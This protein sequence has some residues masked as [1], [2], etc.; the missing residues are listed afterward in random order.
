M[1][2]GRILESNLYTL[3]SEKDI[4]F[5]ASVSDESTVMRA[6]HIFMN[7][8]AEHLIVVI[9]GAAGA[10]TLIILISWVSVRTKRRRR[11]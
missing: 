1:V 9:A 2:D 11:Q 3:K 5:M 10:L 4:T 6:V 8:T 7:Y